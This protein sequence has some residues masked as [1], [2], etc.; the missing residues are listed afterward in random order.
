MAQQTVSI[1]TSANDG[2]GDPLRTAFTKINTMFT[3]LYG[4]TAEANA[5][6]D[7]EEGVHVVTATDT[8]GGATYTLTSAYNTLAYTKIGRLVTITGTLVCNSVTGTPSGTIA[9]TLPFSCVNTTDQGGR[10]GGAG[11]AFYQVQK[12][13]SGEYAQHNI[14]EG[15]TVV[16]LRYGS[17]G[18]NS[19]ETQFNT[20]SQVYCNFSY[21][22]A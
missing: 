4:D 16:T 5:L 15:V 10:S 20:S 13:T 3:E 7:Y 1:G 12:Y 18:G 11:I 17:V 2:T 14:S 19:Y 8:G 22:T 6:G 9:L 21:F